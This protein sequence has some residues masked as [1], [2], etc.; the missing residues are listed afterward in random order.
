MTTGDLSHLAQDL[1]NTLAP[2][3]QS[4]EFTDRISGFKH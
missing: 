4:W 3:L 2:Y 1:V